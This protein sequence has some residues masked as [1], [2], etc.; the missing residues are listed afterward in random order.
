MGDVVA[1]PARA[2]AELD[3]ASAR[4]RA[5]LAEARAALR[6]ARARSLDPA[7]RA[8]GPVARPGPVE[9]V[10]APVGEPVDHRADGG[11]R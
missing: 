1:F 7:D 10:T 6:R 9:A 11:G 2:E 8:E 4:N 5:G 3:P